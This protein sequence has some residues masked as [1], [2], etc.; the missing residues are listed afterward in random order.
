MAAPAAVLADL[1]GGCKADCGQRQTAAVRELRNGARSAESAGSAT[2]SPSAP[3]G[4]DREGVAGWSE[5]SAAFGCGIW[6]GETLAG[7]TPSSSSVAD[8]QAEGER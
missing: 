2:S 6:G 1:G 4:G 5:G 3:R 8:A 7:Q